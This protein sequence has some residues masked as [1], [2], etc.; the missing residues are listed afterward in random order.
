MAYVNKAGDDQER[1]KKESI[2]ELSRF[3]DK[4]I[5]VK[6]TGGREASIRKTTV[7]LC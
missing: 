2:L 7:R 3:I 1:K 4:Q 6:F 5:R